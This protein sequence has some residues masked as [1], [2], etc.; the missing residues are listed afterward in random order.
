MFGSMNNENEARPPDRSDVAR[1]YRDTSPTNLLNSAARQV[2]G[3]E[4]RS[5]SENARALALLNMATSDS[6]VASFANKYRYNFWRPVTAIRAGLTDG[7]PQ[8]DADTSFAP[9]ITTPCFPSY[10]SNHASGTGGGAE[11]L[12]RMYGAGGHTITVSSPN[13]VDA[14]IVLHYTTFKAITND[15][16]D[17]RV[18]GGIHF[19]F[20]QEA[21]GR[22]GRDIATYVVKHNLRPIDGSD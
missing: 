16:D 20:D 14:G 18:F 3:A 11:V 22:L 7:N 5:L 13:P 12:R 9:Y 2:A 19:R 15:V 6:L 21:G 10:P 1:I 17:A 8:T 4:G